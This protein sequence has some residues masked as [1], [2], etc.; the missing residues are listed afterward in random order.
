M[1]KTIEE[2]DRFNVDKSLVAM[3]LNMSPEERVK[4]ND[5]AAHAILEL[6]HAFQQKQDNRP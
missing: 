4:A 5:N 6:R 2:V 3:F 1:K